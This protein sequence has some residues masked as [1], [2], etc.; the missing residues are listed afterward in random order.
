MSCGSCGQ[1]LEL[2]SPVLAVSFPKVTR[3]LVRGPCC[4]GSEPPSDL[5]EVIVPQRTTTKMRP[6]KVIARPDV[7]MRQTGEG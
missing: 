4:A 2:G 7:K 5:P 1:V 3:R 6:L